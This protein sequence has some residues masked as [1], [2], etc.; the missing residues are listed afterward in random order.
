[1]GTTKV[2]MKRT[3]LLLIGILCIFVYAVF[4]L[5]NTQREPSL[6]SP[7][8]PGQSQDPQRT[9][10]RIQVGA[11]SLSV[12]VVDTPEKI[13]K[14]LGYR[15]TLG[16]DGMLF[17]MPTRSI[18]TFW[19]KGMRFDL[20]FVWIDSNTVVDLSAN[21]LAEPKVPDAQLKIYSPKA[22]VTHVLELPSG[23]IEKKGIRIGD[24]V[25]L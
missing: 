15:D 7:N 21:V 19:M 16:S 10:H 2:F 17:V 13:T 23:D 9:M 20:D 11:E 14:G 5:N 4:Y 3:H 24:K 8:S 12:E 6:I 22:P 18:P 1:M 25:S